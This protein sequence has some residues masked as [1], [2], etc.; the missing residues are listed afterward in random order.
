[1]KNTL[2]CFTGIDGS[3]KTTIAKEIDQ[4]LRK[5][6]VNSVYVYGRVI[7]TISRLFMWLGRVFI[8]K[9]RKNSIFKDYTNYSNEKSKIFSNVFLAKLFELIMLTDHIIQINLKI[10]ILLL[11]EKCV[12][13]DRY[14]HDTVITD[15]SANLGYDSVQSNILIKK[16]LS[17][18]PKPDLIFYIDIP[19]EIAYSR[20]DDVPHINYLQVRK[21]LYDDLER[22]FEIIKIDGAETI[23]E[24]TNLSYMEIKKFKGG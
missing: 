4:K 2:I 16:T 19:E 7:P 6:N 5:N 12:I 22:S 15:I 21:K 1:L 17:L 20:K 11:L 18:V 8:L 24:I 3:G 13:C 10:R 23:K 14:I 9:K